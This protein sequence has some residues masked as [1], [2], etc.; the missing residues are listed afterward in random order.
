MERLLIVLT[1]LISVDIY[2]AD[3]APAPTFCVEE[4]VRSGLPLAD[5]LSKI[6]REFFDEKQPEESVENWY[7]RNFFE[8]K[9]RV[10]SNII[11]QVKEAI[12]A[13][14]TIDKK[15]RDK[16]FKYIDRRYQTILNIMHSVTISNVRVCKGEFILQTIKPDACDKKNVKCMDMPKEIVKSLARFFNISE[17]LCYVQELDYDGK[18]DYSGMEFAGITKQSDVNELKEKS[19]LYA[20]IHIGSRLL[21]DACNEIKKCFLLHEFGHVIN[22]DQEV[23][24]CL[25][26]IIRCSSLG[27]SFKS[28]LQTFH[29][30]LQEYW[31]D[32][33]FIC[34]DI[35]KIQKLIDAFQIVAKKSIKKSER[36]PCLELRISFLKQL[37][38]DLKKYGAKVGE[39]ELSPSQKKYEWVNLPRADIRV[40]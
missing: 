18:G 13:D 31:A 5:F 32:I 6:P 36:H 7:H 2:A 34:T 19:L 28:S 14:V 17:G 30:F 20:R 29:F 21:D 15:E 16:K 25:D 40:L 35:E 11:R 12:E 26:E 8:L 27:S 37:I 33:F 9:K 4:A 1:L 39:D 3:A 22:I 23:E 24:Y 38:V 10:I